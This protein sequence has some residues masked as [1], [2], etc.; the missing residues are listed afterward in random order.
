MPYVT[1]DEN[2]NITGIFRSATE[3]ASEEL[4]ADDPEIVEFLSDGEGASD[5]KWEL[6]VSD[7]AMGR[8]AEDLVDVLIDK[9]ILSFTDLPVGSQRKLLRRRHLRNKLKSVD[10]IM[11][12]EG[13]VL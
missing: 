3:Q 11:T 5:L 2:G 1:R 8:L 9:N 4:A 10:A 7:W 6:F 12:D 13:G